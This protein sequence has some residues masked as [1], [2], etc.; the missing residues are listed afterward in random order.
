M[1]NSIEKII[2]WDCFPGSTLQFPLLKIK[3][4]LLE[5]DQSVNMVQH[6]VYIHLK[7]VNK[8]AMIYMYNN[9]HVILDICTRTIQSSTIFS[10]ILFFLYE[11]FRSD[12]QQFNQ[13][14]RNVKISFLSFCVCFFL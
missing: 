1:S 14:S 6:H 3:I 7:D 10:I 5:K 12:V 11:R 8:N 9:H 13:C 4:R 2:I